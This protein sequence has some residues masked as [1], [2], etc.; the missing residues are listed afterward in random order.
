[1]DK[2]IK[3][4]KLIANLVSVFVFVASLAVCE[5][6]FWNN[7]IL[8]A[9]HS[10]PIGQEVKMPIVYTVFSVLFVAILFLLLIFGYK[11]K[12]KL[13]ISLSACFQAVF[14]IGFLLFILFSLGGITNESL[15]VAVSGSISAII[16]PVYGFIWFAGVVSL[17]VFLVLFVLTFII[18]FKFL[19]KKR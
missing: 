4:N 9:F 3:R 19:K 2:V 8:D 10:T 1:M 11:L 5:F 14:I 13:M 7:F 16:A 15:M 12:N 6:L 18:L 17:V